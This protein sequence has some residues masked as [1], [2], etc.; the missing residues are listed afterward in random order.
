[1]ADSRP[2]AGKG[3]ATGQDAAAKN[4]PQPGS[5]AGILSRILPQRAACKYSAFA[6]V[7]PLYSRT[8]AAGCAAGRLPSGTIAR[9]FAD[10]F[11]RDG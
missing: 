3:R 6:V 11:S 4:P 2:A 1:M 10:E 9:A 5:R 8:E 7:G